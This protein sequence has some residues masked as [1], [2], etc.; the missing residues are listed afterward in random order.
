VLDWETRLN[1]AVGA[2]RGL[3]YLHNDSEPSILHRD[4][5]SANILLDAK[6]QA[7]V[8]G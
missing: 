5:K 3:S 1:I 2:A 8:R 7:Q 4:V 6:M